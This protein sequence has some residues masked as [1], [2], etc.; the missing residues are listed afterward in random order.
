MMS[1]I[2]V[3][4][5]VAAGMLYLWDQP[6]PRQ[7]AMDERQ[8]GLA[9]FFQ[10]GNEMSKKVKELERQ[11]TALKKDQRPVGYD[12][13]QRLW[14]ELLG[15]WEK[16][17]LSKA[18]AME[19]Y[20]LLADVYWMSNP[21]QTAR[22]G[23]AHTGAEGDLRSGD[24]Q[25]ET[26]HGVAKSAGGAVQAPAA[27]V[28]QEIDR[29]AATPGMQSGLSPAQYDALKKQLDDLA[30]KGITGLEQY[31]L[32]IEER[33]PY[34]VAEQDK[35][36]EAYLA[37]QKKR[38]EDPYYDCP[39]DT[40]PPT[41][42]ADFTDF[43][44]LRMITPPGTLTGDRDVAKGHFW[45]WTG[46]AKVPLYVPVDAI[47]ESMSSGPASAKDSTIHSTLNFKVKDRCG[48]TFRFAHVTDPDRSLQ[49]GA[50]L[51]AG[52]RVA[53]TIGN[54]PSGNW[55]IGFYNRLKEGELAKI[56]AFGLHRHG[57]CLIDYYP[58]EKRQAYRALFD[59]AGPR[60]VCQ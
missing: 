20:Q 37:E 46:G 15:L 57:V 43:S 28:R 2:F 10:R 39:K 11:L 52:T 47:F 5:A 31:Y 23:N 44:V 60:S 38:Q 41:L 50:V 18:R 1:K 7:M 19:L 55:D 17:A 49:P 36:R 25:G 3:F 58:S 33:S 6:L 24:A 54:I 51:P 59:P 32:I 34:T 26:A 14:K 27:D 45:I 30:G 48:F 56:N 35:K 22:Q 13:I 8:S 4:A 29:I 12:H 53:Y 21:K 16:G 42:T 40:P 9:L